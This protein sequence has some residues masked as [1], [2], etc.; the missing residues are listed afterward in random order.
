[1]HFERHFALNYIFFP[2]KSLRPNKRIP[3]FRVT[4]PYPN[5]LM[6]PRIFSGF[7]EKKYNFMNLN[8]ILPFKVHRLIYFPRK[9]P[10]ASGIIYKFMHF[11]L[12]FVFQNA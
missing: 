10:K 5:L 2:E 1:M 6:R 4:P 12:H 8:G 3:V 11:E 9:K 7:L